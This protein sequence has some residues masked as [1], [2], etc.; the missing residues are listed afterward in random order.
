MSSKPSTWRQALPFLVPN[1]A[2]FTVFMLGPVVAS[3][4]LSFCAWDLL[5]PP[6][7]VGFA[8]FAELL[9][10]QRD[11][12]GEWRANDPQFWQYLWN[13]FVLLLNLPF[14]LVGSLALAL[15]LN[16][17]LAGEKLYRLIFF[18]PSVISGVAVFYL[19]RWMLNPGEGMINVA[20][21]SLGIQ[22][23]EWLADPRWAK[24]AILIMSFWLTIGGGGMILFL[25]ALQ[26]VPRELQEAAEIDGAGPWQSF[27]IVTWPAL[28]PV[29]FF[30]VT[31]GLIYGL[32]TGGEM[33]Y[34]M[35]NGGPAGAT[36][37]LG[38]Y[39]FQKAY[40]QFEMGY[41]AAIS[42]VIFA[43]VF[44]ITWVRWK[45]GGDALGGEVDS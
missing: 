7:W 39:V 41:A 43:L 5:S 15:L 6:K 9:G 16:R 30:I 11:V 34:I 45:R 8:N 22:G 14:S 21:S 25:A 10:F 31:T 44:V 27:L 36:T 20:L 28:K 18:L 4:L 23:P 12:T 19:W 24:P 26:N 13:T 32:Q 29:T 1:L 37:T 2:G 17:K 38:Y 35:T 40:Q 42:W 33:A 3:L